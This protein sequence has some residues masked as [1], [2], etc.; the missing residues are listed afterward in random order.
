MTDLVVYGRLDG[1]QK[2][3]SELE[4]V[5]RALAEAAGMSIEL[6]SAQTEVADD[7]DRQSIVELLNKGK[8]AKALALAAKTKKLGIAEA[9]AYVGEIE[10][11]L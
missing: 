10:A 5:V 6:P 2:R 7:P 4:D 3:V 1:L 8:R 9:S 11:S